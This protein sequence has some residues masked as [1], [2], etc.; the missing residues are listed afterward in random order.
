MSTAFHQPA[1]PE[2]APAGPFDRL[3]ATEESVADVLARLRAEGFDGD[4]VFEPEDIPPGLFCRSCARRH[5]PA[6]AMVHQVHRFEGPTSPEDEAIVVAVTCPRCGARGALVTAY[7]AAATAE[8]A[9]LHVALAG[10]IERTLPTASA[11]RRDSR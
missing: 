6:R 7:G 5:L 4:V 3:A 11:S 9:D 10:R 2:E 1:H 8:E